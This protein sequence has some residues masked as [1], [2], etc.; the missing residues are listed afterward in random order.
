MTCH[1]YHKQLPQENEERR[2]QELPKLVMT[3]NFRISLKSF[4]IL[5]NILNIQTN[6][7]TNLDDDA[8]LT[9]KEARFFFNELKREISEVRKLLEISGVGDYAID[10]KFIDVSIICEIS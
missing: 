1:H 7:S 9:R 6:V 4:E 5:R 10:E 2:Q 8:P 3:V